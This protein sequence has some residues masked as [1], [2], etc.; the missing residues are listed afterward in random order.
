MGEFQVNITR[1]V[2]EFINNHHAVT[3]NL[4]EIRKVK[5]EINTWKK[6]IIDVINEYK[7]FMDENTGDGTE[8]K[9]KDLSSLQYDL[10]SQKKE[11]ME[12]EKELQSFKKK[13]EENTPM[14]ENVT[15][16]ENEV[17]HI[18]NLILNY[19]LQGSSS[20]THIYG[21]SSQTQ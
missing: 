4:I 5:S 10:T 12:I 6:E 9:I 7:M 13:Q 19:G 8:D 17:K 18:E 20:K 15:K 3:Y 1:R 11:I 2:E 21:N 16:L 14:R